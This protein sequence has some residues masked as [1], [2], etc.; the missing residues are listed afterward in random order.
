MIGSAFD[1][2]SVVA[3]LNKPYESSYGGNE[4][5]IQDSDNSDFF[6]DG[7]DSSRKIKGY[8]KIVGVSGPRQGFFS[9]VIKPVDIEMVELLKK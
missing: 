1:V 4:Y 7:R 2:P 6:F 5:I 8:F 3:I 9:V